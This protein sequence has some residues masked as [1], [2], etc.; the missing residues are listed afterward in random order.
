M[1]HEKAIAVV[2]QV[3]EKSQGMSRPVYRGQA[4]AAW[5][6]HSGAVRRLTKTPD[7]EVLNDENELRKQVDQ[8]HKEHLT[9]PMGVIDGEEMSFIQ[10]LSVLQHHG[11]ATGLLDFTYNPLV[12]LWFACAEPSDQNGKVFILDIGDPLIAENGRSLKDPFEVRPKIVYYEPDRELGARIAAQQSVFVVCN[13]RIPE[14]RFK[15]IEL[16]K[17]TK[18]LVREYLPLVGI[19]EN[20]LFADVP[21]LAAANSAQAPLPK[22]TA[23]TSDE[24]RSRGNRLHQQQRY[25]EALPYYE[26]YA[27]MRPNIAASHAL[28][29]DTFAALQRYDEAIQAYSDAI[30]NVDRPIDAGPQVG[31]SSAIVRDMQHVLHFNRDNVRAAVEDHRGAVT[32]FDEA[33]KHGSDQERQ[34]LYNRGNSK[35]ALELFDEA[36]DDFSAAKSQREGSDIALAMGN[37]RIRAGKFEEAMRAYSDGIAGEPE[38]A[39]AH[40]RENAARVGRILHALTGQDYCLN[41]AGVDLYIID[42][43]AAKE[44]EIFRFPGNRGN[45]GNAASGMTSALGGKGYGGLPGFGVMIR[46]ARRS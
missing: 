42:I 22:K 20:Q 24:L 18:K 7:D 17:K 14:K 9:L 25:A 15:V 32:D 8:Y 19:S 28:K 5:E 11:A 35:F 34:V 10:R 4:D 12:A 45:T 31:I 38:D 2:S 16:S 6:P 3:L 13:P 43:E 33:L 46:P 27:E 1:T 40:C 36:Y 26:A 30:R 39:A 29:G 23:P 41:R 44:S 21:G 37:C